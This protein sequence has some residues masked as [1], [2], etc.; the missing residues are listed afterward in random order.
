M[1][2]GYASLAAQAEKVFQLD[3]VK[4]HLFVSRGRRGDLVKVVLEL[5]NNT[6]ERAMRTVALGRKNHFF[7]GSP[8]GGRA[9]AV[10]YTLTEMAKL[11]GVD[12]RP[13]SPIRP[14][15]SPTTRS[16]E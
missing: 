12:P 3:P 15:A 5:H 2:K 16:P 8:D 9:A 6:A 4:G 1:R 11:N 7:I 10:A 14:L 13:G